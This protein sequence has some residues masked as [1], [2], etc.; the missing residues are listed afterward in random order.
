M[1]TILRMHCS[2]QQDRRYMRTHRLPITFQ[3]DMMYTHTN[4]LRLSRRR[5]D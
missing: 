4:H 1:R 5:R 2:F 3:E